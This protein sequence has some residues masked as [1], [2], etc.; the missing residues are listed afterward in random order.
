MVGMLHA[1]CAGGVMILMGERGSG[2]G[3][4]V[5]RLEK[6][7]QMA[8]LEILKGEENMG[9][10]IRAQADDDADD[11]VGAHWSD[12]DREIM[13]RAEQYAAWQPVLSACLTWLCE[14]ARA[15]ANAASS[16]ANGASRP[17]GEEEAALAA[18]LARRLGASDARLAYGPELN[19]VLGRVVYP[20][21]SGYTPPPEATRGQVAA[22]L[23]V[24][25]A[26]EAAERRALLIVLHLTTST[27]ANA[28]LNVNAWKVANAIA[29]AASRRH[30]PEP[31]MLLC[32]V[33]RA[34]MISA[35]FA[36]V[37]AV[38]IGGAPTS[39]LTTPPAALPL[40]CPSPDPHPPLP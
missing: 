15:S 5:K 19:A 18:L 21:P 35:R 6:A 10:K 30:P 8:G 9:A 28:S 17:G 40:T 4:M 27:S 36:E 2:K 24:C 33:S 37:R 29:R 38:R 14:A 23:A 22:D 13:G 1:Y 3:M 7:G 25:I 31:T 20:A 32:I 39:R 16:P 11:A 34:S 12:E 26:L